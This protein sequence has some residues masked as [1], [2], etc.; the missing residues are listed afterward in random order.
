MT[1]DEERALRTRPRSGGGLSSPS[2]IATLAALA[3]RIGALGVAAV[4][5]GTAT[6]LAGCSVAVT[7]KPPAGPVDAPEIA[8][9]IHSRE[10]RVPLREEKL[11]DTRRAGE[12]FW[13]IAARVAEQQGARV[14]RRK[15][16]TRSTRVELVVLDT[17]D[18]RLRAQGWLLTRRGP[19]EARGD[20]ATAEVALESQSPDI[21]IAGRAPIQAAPDHPSTLR[22]KEEVIADA[23]RSHGATTLFELESTVRK[24]LPQRDL[25]LADVVSLFPGTAPRLGNTSA[26][27]EPVGGLRME[28]LELDLGEVRLSPTT[29]A[30][31][32][33]IVLRDRASGDFLGGECVF[34]EKIADYATQSPAELQAERAYFGALQGAAA[35]WIA[36]ATPAGLAAIAYARTPRS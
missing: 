32:T 6:Q 12:D 31:A 20:I 15:S 22:F 26:V 18:Q 4:L 5:V 11:G 7:H 3:A 16:S 17:A 34:A 14:E 21:R 36:P 35:D 27:L 24:A 33:L 19:K 30:K 25:S 13:A 9:E 2:G 1:G 10:Y 23:G 28:K 29:S 8:A